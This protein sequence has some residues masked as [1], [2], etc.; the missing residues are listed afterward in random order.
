[1]KGWKNV[2][3]L[4][5]LSCAL[6]LSLVFALAAGCAG[7]N[8]ASKTNEVVVPLT[9]FEK[10][11]M[12]QVK[13][14]VAKTDRG[15]K[16]L[17]I[18]DKLHPYVMTPRDYAADTSALTPGTGMFKGTLLIRLMDLEGGRQEV[19]PFS[20]FH[21]V[22][23]VLFIK[24]SGGS[25]KEIKVTEAYPGPDGS[26]FVRGKSLQGHEE[27]AFLLDFDFRKRLNVYKGR[28]KEQ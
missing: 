15:E 8:I 27:G 7:N 3:K 12:Q 13:K 1:M 4:C 22:H 5:V 25:T 2:K 19:A 28:V 11:W 24:R 18:H 9:H 21:R 20:N 16:I 17:R 14:E 23:G 6:L 26:L 10:A